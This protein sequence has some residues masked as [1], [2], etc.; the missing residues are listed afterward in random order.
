MSKV[1]LF[2]YDHY[3]CFPKDHICSKATKCGYVREN[4]TT[5]ISKVTC[6]LCLREINKD[7]IN[8]IQH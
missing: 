7:K 5:D 4:V 3:K 1:H 6:K 2:D 8:S